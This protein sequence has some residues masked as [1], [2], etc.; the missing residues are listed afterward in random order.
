MSGAVSPRT[1]RLPLRRLLTVSRPALWVNTVGTLVT[2]VWLS[3]R[4]YTLDPATLLLL[5]YLTLPFALELLAFSEEEGV[6]FGVPF[7]GS[8]ALTG[9]LEP[10]LALEDAR[11]VSVRGALEAYGLDP[12]ELPGARV[13]GPSLGFLEIH[14][15]QGPVLQAAGASVGVVSAIAG[16][17]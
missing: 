17:D 6:R 4:L 13:T 10:L 2:G 12:A 11:G 14:I 8:R 1:H 15:E 5:A 3:G 16:Q 7:I 9:T